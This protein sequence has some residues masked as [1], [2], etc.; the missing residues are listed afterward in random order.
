MDRSMTELARRQHGIVT[1]KQLM[2]LG[3]SR[4]AVNNRVGRGLLHAVYPGVYSVGGLAMSAG[5]RRIAAVFACKGEAVLSHRSAARLW[6]V[7]PYDPAVIEVSRPRWGRTKHEG[8]VLHQA[9]LLADEV[10]ELDGI[11]L[12]SVFRTILDLAA[13]VSKREVE[14]AFHE[15]EVRGLTDRVSL[16][17]LLERY[18][19]RRG[20][21][22]VREILASPEPSGITEN[23]FEEAFVAFLDARG[24][25]RPFFNATLPLRG[26]LLRPDCMWPDDRLIAELDGRAVHGTDDAFESDRQRD[27]I[28]VAAGWRS[29]RIT[30]RQ[31]RDEPG[32]I[33]ADLRDSL[34]KRD[35][36]PH[37]G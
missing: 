22:T 30:W 10:D 9:R 37:G 2:S 25:P 18:P 23:G 21:A 12:T 33:A 34:G 11:P 29:M 31:L 16:P 4:H 27:R 17:Q 15:T 19:G 8:V 6:G 3:M 14:R 7:Y 35:R 28:L 32:A 1:R 24:L 26:R 13:V 20:V 36:H 5:G